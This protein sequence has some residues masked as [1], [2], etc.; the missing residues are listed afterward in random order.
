MKLVIGLLLLLLAIAGGIAYT[1]KSFNTNPFPVLRS[2]TPTATINNHSFSLK[3][4]K[5]PKD[6]EVGLSQ[7]SSLPEDQGMVFIFESAGS[8]PF[9]MRDMQFPIDIIFVKDTNIVT[10]HH[11]VAPPKPQDENL[12][13]FTPT[14]P[15]DKVLEIHAGLAK[16]YNIKE[17][18]TITFENL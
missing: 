14:S 7:T 4:A 18:D 16:K 1:Q 11:N 15:A 2:R 12:P 9:W 3:V 5:D 8:Y 13:V 17:G 6:I 10:I